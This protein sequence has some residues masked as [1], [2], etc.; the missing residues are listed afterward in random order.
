MIAPVFEGLQTERTEIR[1]AYDDDYVYAAGR[2]YDS[3]PTGIRGNSLERDR[4]SDSDDFFAL[5]LDTFNDNENAMAFL[6]TPAGIRVDHTVFNDADFNGQNMPV[7]ESWN[8]FWD[9]MTVVNEEGW[10]AEMRIPFSSLRFQKTDDAVVM[11]LLTWRW[12]GRKSEGHTYPPVPPKWFLGHLKPSIAQDVTLRGVKQTKPI[13]ITPYGLGGLGHNH[14]LNDAE[15]EYLRDDDVVRDVGVDLKYGLT[16]NLTMD[17]TLNTDFAQVEADD[18]QVNLTRFSL[19]F[20]E[21]RLFF[22]E[23]SSI[24]DFNTGGP[25]RLF[26][27]RRIG[28]TDDGPVRIYGGA[29]VVGRVGA[30]DVGV[31]NMQTAQQSDVPSENFGVAR[32]RRQVLNANSYAGGMIT[33]RIGE[34]G[35]YN[36]AYGADGIFRLFGDDYLTVSWAQ[37]FEDERDPSLKSGLFRA[38]WERRT[39]NGLGYSLGTKWSGADYNPG[40]GFVAREDFALFSGEISY[41]TLGSETSP[42]FSQNLALEGTLFLRN[43]N[44]AVESAE[45]GPQYFGNFKSGAFLFLKPQ[46]R[47]DDLDEGFELSD[48]VEVP[49]GR[50]T[51]YDITAFGSSPNRLYRLQA[52][53]NAG[54]FYDGWRVSVGLEPVWNLNRFL[55]LSG[56]Y[57]FNRVRFAD[58][59]QQL[60]ANIL[61]IRARASMNTQLSANV[62]AQYNSGA[63]AVILNLRIRYNFREGNDLYIVYNEGL[64]TD[65]LTQSP[66]PPRSESRTFLVKYAHT[67]VL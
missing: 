49:A 12:I 1:V 46:V 19:F 32:L 57:E 3:N 14:E 43:K 31:L 59:D 26:Y 17:L 45:F 36:L 35:T 47:F 22:Q 62:F 55:E 6:T 53:A 30:W 10:F 24:F 25:T 18:Q 58:R 5:I 28:L 8:T 51:F 23:R 66:I 37:T 27:S 39:S 11:G 48:E 65:R 54:T 67:F 21:K 63:D 2:F 40:L 9:V 4:G 42:L 38:Q 29:R 7:N 13:Y 15:T 50:Y 33:S 44:G 60:D 20:P 64:N 61:R 34:D 16:S 52:N 56:A 41:G